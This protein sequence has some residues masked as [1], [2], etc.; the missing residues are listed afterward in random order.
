MSKHNPEPHGVD[1][2]ART[3]PIGDRPDLTAWRHRHE[4]RRSSAAQ[5]H[6]SLKRYTRKQK[7][8]RIDRGGG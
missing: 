2:P 8:R 4:L 7:H 5:Q 6:R 1:S 3:D